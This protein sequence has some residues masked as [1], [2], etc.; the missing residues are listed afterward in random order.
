[1]YVTNYG[2]ESVSVIDTQT[3]QVVG[4]P[5][6]VANGPEGVAFTPSGA[7]AYVVAYQSPIV[8]IIDTQ[9][10]QVIGSPELAGKGAGGLAIVPDQ[11]PQASFAKPG[12]GRPGVPVAFDGSGSSDPDGGVGVFDWS[13]GDGTQASNAGPTLRHSF[14]RPG[15]YSVTLTVTDDEGCSVPLVFTGQTASCSGSP[16]AAQTQTVK[17]AYPGVRVRCPVRAKHG[18]C[19]FKLQVV[20]RKK[21]KAG[22]PRLKPLTS[23]SG[24][25]LKAKHS[26]IVSLKPKR[27]FAKKLAKAKKVLVTETQ[28]IEGVKRTLVRKLKIVR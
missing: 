24:V 18:G 20:K 26:A 22:K 27:R 1:M 4:S 13:F 17:V 21:G 9:A 19:K 12:S 3:N 10:S 23:V 7:T 8:S 14:K 2:G 5:I 25:K 16:L 6:P 11:A 28:T 15:T